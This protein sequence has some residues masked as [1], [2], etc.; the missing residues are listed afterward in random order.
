MIDLAKEKSNEMWFCA[1]KNR[2]TQSS[3]KTERKKRENNKH[4]RVNIRSKRPIFM[5]PT[6]HDFH[7][8]PRFRF[9]SLLQHRLV[10]SLD[11]FINMMC[12]CVCHPTDSERYAVTSIERAHTR[13]E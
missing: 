5:N 8:V 7:A 12:S 2:T 4:A 11:D 6:R 13:Q 10:L 9:L 3:R 1:Y